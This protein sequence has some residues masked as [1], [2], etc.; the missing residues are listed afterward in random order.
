MKDKS[1]SILYVSTK[2]KKQYLLPLSDVH[3]G[4]PTCDYKKAIGMRDWAIENDAWVLCLGDIV[5][6]ATRSSPGSGIFEQTLSPQEQQDLAVDF[7]RPLTKKG[8]VLGMVVGNHEWRSA[9]ESGVNIT[10]N[11]CDILSIPYLGHSIFLNAKVGKINYTIFGIH[12]AGGSVT[13]TGKIGAITKL[14]QHREADIFLMGHV[15]EI[16]IG[17]DV[18]LRLNRKRKMIEERKRYYVL[19]GAYL[20]YKGSYGEMKGYAPSKTGTPRIR[21]DGTRYDPHI[22]A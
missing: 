8:L 17:S 22:S 10:K 12:G 14:S 4:A 20:K 21:L 11:I 2:K 6:N 19:T 5:E 16:W 7:L 15:H 1:P 18:V 3:L 9:N 13:T